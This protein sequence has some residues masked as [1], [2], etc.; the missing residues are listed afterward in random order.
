MY[1]FSDQADKDNEDDD[2]EDSTKIYCCNSFS[3]PRFGLKTSVVVCGERKADFTG[4][5]IMHV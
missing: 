2:G 4:I 1:E 5:N 3:G